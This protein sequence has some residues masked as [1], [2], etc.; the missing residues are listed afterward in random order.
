MNMPA[1]ATDDF[2]PRLRGLIDAWCDRRCLPVLAV[3]LPACVG[4]N[5]LTDG[6]GE[7]HDALK[8][9]WTQHRDSL[10]PDEQEAIHELV[11]TAEAVIHR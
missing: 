11:R 5:G 2:F 8:M 3:V 10:L 7:I 4:F 9:V 6:W 1:T